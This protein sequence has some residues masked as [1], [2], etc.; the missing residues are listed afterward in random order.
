MMGANGLQ[1]L[2]LTQRATYSVHLLG[3]PREQVVATIQSEP[4]RLSN[5]FTSLK[6]S[7]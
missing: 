3:G 5:D 4:I 6:S 1:R 7:L 2:G